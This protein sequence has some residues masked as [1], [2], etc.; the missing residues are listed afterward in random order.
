MSLSRILVLFVKAVFWGSDTD[1]FAVFFCI[2]QTPRLGLGRTLFDFR[3]FCPLGG[4]ERE[5]AG[6]GAGER[7]GGGE[8]RGQRDPVGF[9]LF[10]GV[11]LN[12]IERLCDVQVVDKHSAVRWST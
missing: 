8:E 5:V 12:K 2:L 7:G 3:V 9:V 1:R 11:R 6:A 10:A 4:T